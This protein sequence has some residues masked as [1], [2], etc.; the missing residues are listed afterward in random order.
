MS[1]THI[2]CAVDGSEPSL[3]AVALGTQIAGALRAELTIVSVRLFHTDRTA[4]A[5]IQTPEE[6]DEIL[7]KALVVSRQYGFN[8]A[9][10]VQ[11]SG[12]DV[13]IAVADYAAEFGVGMIFVGSAG[14]DALRRFAVGSTSMDLLCKSACPVTI[15]H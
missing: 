12:R 3:R 6:I 9:Q 15:V 11:I 13:A 8:T 5:G 1:I 4:L 2:L 10:V 7:A 14:K